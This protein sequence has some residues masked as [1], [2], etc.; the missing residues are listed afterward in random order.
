MFGA[1]ATPSPGTTVRGPIAR[2]DASTSLLL[3][4]SMVVLLNLFDAVL[5]LVWVH[6]DIATE[7]NVLWGDLVSSAPMLF[8]LVKLTLV[9][10]GVGFLWWAREHRLARVGLYVVFTAYALVFAWHLTIAALVG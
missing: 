6:A 10:V 9:S 7:A 3:I 2:P 5:T 1:P 4:A 8:M